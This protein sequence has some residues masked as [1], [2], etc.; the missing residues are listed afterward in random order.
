MSDILYLKID[1]SIK[2]DHRDISLGDVA[3]LECTD[4]SV[5]CR[6]KA[7]KLLKIK[8]EKQQQYVMSVL[9][10]IELIHQIY[11]KLEI[12]NMGES[13][14]IIEYEPA[15]Y[16]KGRKENIKVIFLCITIFFGSAFSIMAFN[17]D[18]GTA[19]VFRRAY[20][21]MT[22]EVSDG[23]T[24]LELMYAIGIGIGIIVFYN[25]FGSKKITNDPTPIEV[26]MRLYEDDVNTALIDNSE[27]KG[28]KIDVDE[29]AVSRN[30][31]A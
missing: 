16:A 17:N 21:L 18:V 15:A 24:V 1:K 22:G 13:D 2:A 20:Y 12:Q 5:K 11:P 9:K 25:H 3:K 23:Y 19:D 26:Q 28:T 29:A 8:E 4:A 31:R 27:R 14:F 30:R 7:M 6:L 10:V